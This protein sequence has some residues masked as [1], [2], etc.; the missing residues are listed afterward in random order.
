MPA[1]AHLRTLL[2]LARK[3]FLIL[4]VALAIPFAAAALY[5]RQQEV[6]FRAA[7]TVQIKPRPGTWLNASDLWIDEDRRAIPDQVYRA[8]RDAGLAQ[9]VVERVRLWAG[10]EEL[11]PALRGAGSREEFRSRAAA[12]VPGSVGGLVSVTPVADTS[13]Y[14]VSVSGDSVP[15]VVALANAYADEIV[16]LFREENAL[17]IRT[18]LDDWEKQWQERRDSA[19]ARASALGEDLEGLQ[20]ESPGVDFLRRVNLP[21]EQLDAVRLALVE[22]REAQV[23]RQEALRSAKGFLAAAGMS[24]ESREVAGGGVFRLLSAHAGPPSE[25]PRLSPP[26]QALPAVESDPGVRRFRERIAGLQEADLSLAAGSAASRENSVERVALRDRIARIEADLARATETAIAGLARGAEEGA[27]RVARLEQRAAA[28]EA[29]G[30]IHAAALARSEVIQ[31]R[32]DDLRREIDSYDTRLLEAA[33]LR[34]SSIE[35][36]AGAHLLVRPVQEADVA[37]AAQVSPDLPRTY[38][39]AALAALLLAGG[40]LHLIETFDDTVKSREDYDRHV[41]GL[42]F[43]GVVPAVAGMG[44]EGVGAALVRGRTGTPP[45]ES[46]RAI[47]TALRVPRNGKEARTLLLTSPGPREG[48]TTLSLNL[49]ASFAQ[50]GRRTLLIDGDLRRARVHRIAGADN[51]VGLTSVITGKASLAEAV[52]PSGIMEGLD[53][54]PAGPMSPNP[55]ELLASAG[56][57]QVLDEALSGYACVV[58]DSPPLATVTDPCILAPLVDAVILIIAHAETSARLIRRCRESLD[59]VGARVCGAVVNRATP[60]RGFYGDSYYGYEYGYGDDLLGA[61]NGRGKKNGN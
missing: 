56:M 20:R 4:A 13:F 24:L 17:A 41:K 28:L 31:R 36:G 2:F 7:A 15:L 26:V 52:R 19:A 61:G 21:R 42:P 37:R 33:R 34:K 30:R 59:A 48:K 50:G 14:Q 23:V 60:H 8:Q 49:A 11:P 32:V 44:E 9:R 25:D 51:A 40:L 16:G 54:L 18:Q 27:A 39:F 3:H 12:L 43:L 1:L 22:A 45:V 58:I 35:A 47:R 6:V 29:E 38:L 53:L 57:K 46:I 10:Q 5:A 55:A